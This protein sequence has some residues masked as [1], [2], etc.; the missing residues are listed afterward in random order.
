MAMLKKYKVYLILALLMV[1]EAAVLAVIL[2]GSKSSVKADEQAETTA[3]TSDTNVVEIELGSFKVNNTA[4]PSI[5]VRVE[6][7]VYATVDKSHE[8]Q[9]A[10]TLATKQF[11]VKESIVTVLRRADYDTIQEPTLATLKRQIKEATGQVLG[12]QKTLVQGIVIPDF[13]GREM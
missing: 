4:D 2:P 6:C 11:R 7:S 3:V 13:V 8:S 9:F 12:P 1:A 5:P 10:D